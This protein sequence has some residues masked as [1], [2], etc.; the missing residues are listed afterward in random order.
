MGYFKKLADGLNNSPKSEQLS[1]TIRSG[2][3]E[4]RTLDWLRKVRN[5][6]RFISRISESN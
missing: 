3:V 2:S 6:S 5:K 4:E 1:T